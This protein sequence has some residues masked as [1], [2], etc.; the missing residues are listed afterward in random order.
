MTAECVHQDLLWSGSGLRV[1]SRRY[2]YGSEVWTDQRQSDSFGV[3]LPI[4]GAYWLQSGGVTQFVDRGCGNFERPGEVRFGSGITRTHAATALCVDVEDFDAV[5]GTDWPLGERPVSARLD[6]T[7]RHLRRDLRTGV[8]SAEIEMRAVELLG[9]A[10]ATDA[11]PARRPPGTAARHRKLAADVL[12]ALYNGGGSSSLIELA[13]TVGC[14]PFHLSRIFHRT[15]GVTLR[16]YRA[17]ARMRAALDLL[18]QGERDL[19]TVAARCGFA[20]HSHFTRTATAQLG[21][22]P[23]RLRDLLGDAS[24]G[25]AAR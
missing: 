20:D 8:D 16:Q 14:S 24:R 21:T 6:L 19:S 10:L 11:P 23:S 1:E 12:E 3:Q 7:H 5:D 9:A 4:G 25:D 17:W 18:E 2:D 22:T 15:T 13:R